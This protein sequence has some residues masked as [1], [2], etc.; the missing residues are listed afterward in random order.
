[1]GTRERERD[2]WREAMVCDVRAIEVSREH[3]RAI[4][5]LAPYCCCD[6]TGCIEAVRQIDPSVTEILT[7]SGA[8]LD[9]SY[10]LDAQG[11]WRARRAE[12]CSAP[13]WKPRP[14]FLMSC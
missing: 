2:R 7:L 6:M 9:T 12:Q 5:W 8:K 13:T 1:M 3:H 10:H 4:V 11:E 14:I